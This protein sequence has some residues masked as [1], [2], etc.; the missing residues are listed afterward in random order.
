[1]AAL[2]T[3]L[4][5]PGD[6]LRGRVRRDF[7][8]LMH[9]VPLESYN[10][11]VYILLQE[12]LHARRRLMTALFPAMGVYRGGKSLLL[13]WFMNLTAPYTKVARREEREEG[14]RNETHTPV[15]TVHVM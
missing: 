14:A 13:N 5:R 4:A 1:M 8:H 11:G 12:Y 15:L 7:F 2:D 10:A 3:F 6:E 9:E